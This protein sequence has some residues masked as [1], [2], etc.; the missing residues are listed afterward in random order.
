MNA[1]VICRDCNM[2]TPF[3]AYQD[4]IDDWKENCC[5]IAFNTVSEGGIHGI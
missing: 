4:Q 1:R 5:N 2:A 3:D